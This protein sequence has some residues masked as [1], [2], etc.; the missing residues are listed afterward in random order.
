MRVLQINSVCGIRSTGRIAT[1]FALEYE[2]NG[3]ECKIAYGRECVPEQYKRFAVQIGTDFDNKI[4]AFA[5]RMFDNEGF[6]ARKRTM[7]FLKWA[8]E[9]NPDLL[10]LHNIHGYYINVEL[11][12]DWIKSRPQM[13]VKWLLHDCWA[14]TGHCAYFSMVQCEKW[15]TCCSHCEKKH[16][17]PSAFFKD[18]CTNNF[19]RKKD[20]FQCEEYDISNTFKVVGR[21]G[22]TKF[23]EGLSYRSTA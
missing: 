14:F 20:F 8:D 18:N 3:W 23:F 21:F 2:K 13:Q 10:W 12:F 6:N 16:G 9:F 1:D 5:A 19:R 17:Y 15:R 11:L 22:E 7:K 4:D